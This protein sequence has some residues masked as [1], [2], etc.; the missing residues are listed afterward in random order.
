MQLT[1]T[2]LTS[3]CRIWTY[4]QFF[5]ESS[6]TGNKIK[7]AGEISW[8]HHDNKVKTLKIPPAKRSHN[9]IRVLFRLIPANKIVCR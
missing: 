6:K 7:F 5:L 4:K 8:Q 1:D 3:S 2:Q 9:A